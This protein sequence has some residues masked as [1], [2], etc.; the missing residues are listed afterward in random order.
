MSD[1]NCWLCYYKAMNT[2][3]SFCSLFEKRKSFC[4]KYKNNI[5]IDGKEYTFIDPCT[6]PCLDKGR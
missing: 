6:Q 4:G 5:M 1:Q 3:K 2:S